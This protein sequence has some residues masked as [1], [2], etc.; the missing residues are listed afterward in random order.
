M[1]TLSV[2]VTGIR[3]ANGKI[4]LTLYR[5]SKQVATETVGIDAKT[6]TAKAVFANIPPGT[7]AV[8]LFHDE[9]NNRDFDLNLMGIPVEGYGMSNNPPR[10]MGR[11]GFDETNFQVNQPQCAI[12]IK[13]IYW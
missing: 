11:P 3:N 10:R 5:D 1:S 13:M 8:E 6:L 7:Y 2:Q 9:N 4:Q 12:E